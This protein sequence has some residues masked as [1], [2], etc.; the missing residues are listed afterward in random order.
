MTLVNAL[1][2]SPVKF[3]RTGYA[4][5]PLCNVCDW[6]TEFETDCSMHALWRPELPKQITWLRCLACKHVFTEGYFEG[7]AL[8]ALFEK[9][10]PN[11][12]PGH[13]VE[14]QRMVSAKLIERVQRYL[15]PGACFWLDVGCGS[16]SL[17]S[18]ACEFG[19]FVH[20][21]DLR[22]Y[23]VDALRQLGF[24]VVCAELRDLPSP[25]GYSLKDSEHDLPLAAYDVISMADVLEHVPYP[26]DLLV[27]AHKRLNDGGCVFISCPS[28]DSPAWEMLGERNPY[29]VEIEH[30]HNFSRE[31]LFALLRE[32]GFEPVYFGV[33]ERY[34]LGMEVVAKK[35]AS[36]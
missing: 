27:E 10:H 21:I 36:S 24:A 4:R 15:K 28:A 31:R 22:P 32:V 29:W 17:L 6:E 3:P 9:A 35:H 33:S 23:V 12:L 2:V 5:C 14:L 25:E 16:G 26:K 11:Q 7:D 30:F 19:F 18:T 8:K 13:E 1:R 34:R 20:G